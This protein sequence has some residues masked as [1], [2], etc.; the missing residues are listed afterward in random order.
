MVSP[1]SIFTLDTSISD[2]SVLKAS[3]VKRF[4]KEYVFLASLAD[5]SG[6]SICG[7]VGIEL[8]RP[9]R[10]PSLNG[11]FLGNGVPAVRFSGTAQTQ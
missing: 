7:W 5:G 9:R 10:E 1:P 11:G 3:K 6:L 2:A 4:T 8:L